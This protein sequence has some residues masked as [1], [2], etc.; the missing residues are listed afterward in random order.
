V[1]TLETL[2]RLATAHAKMRLSKIVADS[3]IE[4]AAK[5]LNDTIFQENTALIKSEEDDDDNEEIKVDKV[6]DMNSRTVRMKDR[7]KVKTEQSPSKRVKKEED[8]KSPPRKSKRGIEP[9]QDRRNT[10]RLKV[11][12]DGHFR[13]LF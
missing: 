7:S 4:I 8:E 5:L 6:G 12:E 3:D 13:E 1:R 11:D 10:K 2:I 9:E